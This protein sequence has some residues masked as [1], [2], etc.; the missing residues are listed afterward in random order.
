MPPRPRMRKVST[1]SDAASSGTPPS[2]S[3]PQGSST[4]AMPPPPIPPQPQKPLSAEASALSTCLQNMVVKTGQ[5][6]S[7][8]ADSRRLGIGKHAPHP[9]PSLTA[10]LGR[11]VEKY[12]Q[13]CDA[14]E[15]HLSRAIAVLQRDLERE[16][17]RIREE[18]RL[19]A[20]AEAAAAAAE[21][22][23]KAAESAK[24]ADQVSTSPSRPLLASPASSTADIHM[25]PPNS[26]RKPT[27][28]RQS[29]INI[30]SLHRPTL[31]GK[32][33]L[34][35]TALAF[36]PDDPLHSAL[37]SPVTLAPKTSVPR[38]SMPPP[39]F[40]SQTIDLTVPDDSDMATIPSDNALG[41][42][43]DKPIE[44]DLDDLFSG[45]DN[46]ESSTGLSQAQPPNSNS[47]NVKTE[48]EDLSMDMFDNVIQAAGHS[49]HPKDNNNAG[50]VHQ[51]QQEMNQILSQASTS[52]QPQELTLPLDV[53]MYTSDVPSFAESLVTG[54]SGNTGGDMS[55]DMNM[56]M[57]FDEYMNMGGMEELFDIN[58][59]DAATG[60]T[61]PPQ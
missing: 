26:E 59:V 3:V 8:H 56:N 30:S 11:E 19:K 51:M 43:A 45:A 49:S 25:S 13:L 10:S 16:Q 60:N 6:Y 38:S 35:S 58:A 34:S 2:T 12:D 33:D 27:P 39:D 17:E 42:S 24:S 41:S 36:N 15:T 22:L 55:I 50:S 29:T 53:H 14:L 21:A 28:R 9:P 40:S 32:L 47:V 61:G 57:N 7:F 44:L 48:N 46:Q 4:R 5:I 54:S 31:P 18:E 37:A 20:E 1:V 23:K 52:Q